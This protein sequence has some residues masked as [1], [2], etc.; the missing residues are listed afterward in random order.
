MSDRTPLSPFRVNWRT[1][2]QDISS[3]PRHAHREII[4]ISVQGAVGIAD[5]VGAR[6]GEFPLGLTCSRAKSAGRLRQACGANNIT[7]SIP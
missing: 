2:D 1:I 7:S 5:A 6:D 3:E 4:C